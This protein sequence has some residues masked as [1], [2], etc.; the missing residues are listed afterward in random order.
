MRFHA[1]VGNDDAQIPLLK[2]LLKMLGQQVL[3]IRV[4][5]PLDNPRTTKDA[6]PGVRRAVEELQ[7]E[8]DEVS[9]NA[10]NRRK[11]RNIW[12]WALP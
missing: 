9:G 7:N 3:S 1:V 2:P 8:L 4:H 12:N 6:L 5:G 10:P 11:K